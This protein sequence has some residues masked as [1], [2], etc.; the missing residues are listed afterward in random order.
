MAL[1]NSE[2]ESITFFVVCIALL[3]LTLSG[4]S[5]SS[6]AVLASSSVFFLLPRMLLEVVFLNFPLLAPLAVLAFFYY[7]SFLENRIGGAL[8][9]VAVVGAIAVMAGA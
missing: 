9:A 3:S 7:F 8:V 2:P 6:N 5:L 1:L 4:G